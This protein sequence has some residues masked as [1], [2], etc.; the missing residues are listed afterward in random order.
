[1]RVSRNDRMSGLSKGQ[2]ARV[3]LLA[4]IAHRPELLILDEPSSGLDPI[5]RGDILEAIIKTVNE[6]GRTVLFSSHLL[7]EVDR[8][9]DTVGMIHA[10]QMRASLT[11]E[12]LQS[13]YT[14]WVVAV[15]NDLGQTSYAQQEQTMRQRFPGAFGWHRRGEEWSAVW[16]RTGTP[17]RSSDAGTAEDWRRQE[18]PITLSR[19]FDAMARDAEVD[20]KPNRFASETTG[21]AG[22]TDH[23]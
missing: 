18:R 23:D 17:V 15:G 12:Q 22:G 1:F 4:A 14:E 16:D 7:D 21:V 19:W 9:C 3:G 2:R 6:D 5:A 20:R 8:V 11:I 13:R 10:G